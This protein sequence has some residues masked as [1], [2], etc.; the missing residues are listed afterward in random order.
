[1]EALVF[2]RR[3]D[4]AALVHAGLQVDVVRALQFAGFLVFDEGIG[5]KRVVRTAHVPPRG[6]SFAF[7]NS[8]R[9]TRRREKWGQADSSADVSGRLCMKPPRRSSATDARLEL[10]VT[11]GHG[12]GEGG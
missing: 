6:R 12:G 8:H 4:L 1:M 10:A 3:Q 7:R 5:A 9:N 11:P 2:L